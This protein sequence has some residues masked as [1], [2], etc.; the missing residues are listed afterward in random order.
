M[1]SLLLLLGVLTLSTSSCWF[2]DDDDNRDCLVGVGPEVTE[3]LPV[4][5]FKEIELTLPAQVFLTQGPEFNVTVIGRA[6]IIDNINLNVVNDRWEIFPRDCVSDLGNMQFFI[7]LPELEA[8]EVTGPGDIISENTFVVGDLDIQ[9]TGTGQ[10]DLDLEAD[11]IEIENS[12]TA[13]ITLSGTADELE[14]RLTGTGNLN[15]FDLPVREA[16]IRVTG[17]GDAEVQVSDQLTVQIVGTG[18]VFYRGNP[19]RDVSITGTGSVVDTN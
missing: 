14:Y 9:L 16:F 17:T 18:I 5:N 15:A 2:E 19:N 7:T 10:V 11:D 4:S 6:N 13:D 8:I 1:R 12:G 3:E